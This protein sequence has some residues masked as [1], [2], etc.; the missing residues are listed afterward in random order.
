MCPSSQGLG[1]SANTLKG[2]AYLQARPDVNP[3]AV[4]LLGWS[5][6]GST[7]LYAAAAGARD[8]AAGPPFARA[9][10]FYPGCRR[11]AE[12]GWR[13][14]VPLHILVGGA[15][16]WTGAEACRALAAAAQARGEP[17]GITVYPGACHDFDHPNLPVRARRGLAYT[18]TG[19]GV[20]HVG[21]DP[22]ARAD[23][24]RRVPALLAR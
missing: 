6:G 10:A 3:H 21:T 16:D 1:A 9:V 14:G 12:S 20:A 13:D 18:A 17:V 11:A 4:S 24:L 8:P 2:L 19:T 15:D 5:N 23:A 22:A 7:V